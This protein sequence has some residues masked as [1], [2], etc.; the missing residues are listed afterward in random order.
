MTQKELDKVL[1]AQGIKSV[2]ILFDLYD[3]YISSGSIDGITLT[4]D[5]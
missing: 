1:G 2:W 3:S 4:N 5:D